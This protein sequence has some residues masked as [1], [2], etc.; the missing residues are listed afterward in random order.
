MKRLLTALL[1]VVFGVCALFTFACAPKQYKANVNLKYFE[2]ATDLMPMLKQGQMSIGLMPEPA[3]STLE[4]TSNKTWYRLDVQ[5]LYNGQ[6]K[7]YP[8]AVLMV[9][10]SLLASYPNLPSQMESAFE[11]NVA[12]VKQN[13]SLAVNAVNSALA[14]GV[15][16]SLSAG[17]INS[18]VVDNC[19]IYWQGASNAQQDCKAYINDILAVSAGELNPPAKALTDEFFYT[20]SAQGTFD[21][22]TI[23][24]YAPDGAPALAIAKFINDSQNFGTGI[25]FEYNVVAS[26]NIGGAMQQGI[27]DIIIMPINA[28]SKLYA[29]KGYKMVSVVTHGN[30]YIMSDAPI[31]SIAELKDKTV[32]VIGR[33][34]VPDLTFKAVLN[35]NSMTC[36]V[37]S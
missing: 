16:P 14:S 8:Q 15:T 25:D 35:K 7:A 37:V 17:N 13:A 24:V 33:G 27:A 23:S 10:E 3:A 5:E 1:T 26:S 2:S 19:K 11:D 22:A 4:R 20:G 12:W 29:V 9:K 36:S 30:L 18:T 6:A 21:K 32:G 34:L 31:S 28:A